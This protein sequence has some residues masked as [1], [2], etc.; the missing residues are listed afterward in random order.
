LPG[1]LPADER[2]MA[3]D[4]SPFYSED[5]QRHDAA[6]LG[7]LA[8]LGLPLERRSVLEVGSGPG[9]HTGFYLDR[10]CTLLATDA[11]PACLEAL[12]KRHPRASTAVVDWNFPP[13]DLGAFE[14]VHC[15]GILYHLQYPQQALDA[16]A[17]ACSDLM[18]LETCVAPGSANQLVIGREDARNPTQSFTGWACRPTRLWVFEQ[19][20][21]RFPFVY[22]TRTQPNHPEFPTDWTLSYRINQLIRGVFVASRR[23]L[24][25]AALI[26]QLLDG[27]VP[28]PAPAI[29]DFSP[30]V[31]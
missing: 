13:E 6:R 18:V 16:L 3:A 30:A 24:P 9:G 26:D 28:F 4:L 11:R 12:H 15:Y 14:V 1:E 2:S 23:E 31:I 19:L 21:Q 22:S 29:P 25:P 17:R 8:S 7:H 5:Y 27:Q 20:R 10:G